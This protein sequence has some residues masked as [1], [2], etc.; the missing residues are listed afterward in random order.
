MCHALYLPPRGLLHLIDGFGQQLQVGGV[1]DQA[2]SAHQQVVVV[3]GETFKKPQQ[4]GVVFLG[5]VVAGEFFGPQAFDVPGVEVFVA[6]EAQQGGVAVGG[7]EFGD[8]GF[9]CV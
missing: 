5:V 8:F 9:S 1:V 6:D 3:T 2:G 4:L 7:F